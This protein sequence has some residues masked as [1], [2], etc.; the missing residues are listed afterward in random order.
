MQW[1]P[2]FQNIFKQNLERREFYQ[3]SCL[4]N[5]TNVRDDEVLLYGDH[6]IRLQYDVI[7]RFKDLLEIEIPNWVIDPFVTPIEEIEV[8]NWH[9]YNAMQ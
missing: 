7:N 1:N 8:Q 6:I 3:F 5:N 4:A 2:V 9:I